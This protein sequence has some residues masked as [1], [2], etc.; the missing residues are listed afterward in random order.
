MNTEINENSSKVI[1]L[2]G[3]SGSGKGTQGKFIK[4]F[5]EKHFPENEMHYLS[6]GEEMRRIM[7]QSSYTARLSRDAMDTGKLQ[8]M[9]FSVYVWAKYL[10]EH[11]HGN[12]NIVFDGV[13]RRKEEAKILHSA[14]KFYN[15]GKPV[16]INIDVSE[17]ECVKR[18]M[19][20]KRDD[21]NVENFKKKMDWYKMEV[22]PMLQWYSE[23]NLYHY[24][25]IHGEDSVENISKHIEH[26]LESHYD[27]Q[28]N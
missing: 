17:E 6:T 2:V 5:L 15:W 21:D 4:S 23:S 1:I 20:R 19:E 26:F 10:M 24:V 7:K 22:E 8:P 12:D 14:V 3:R 16:V 28:S 13:P 9:F 11:V 18:M 27:L 25:R